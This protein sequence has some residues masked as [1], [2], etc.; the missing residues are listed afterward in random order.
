MSKYLLKTPFRELKVA[1]PVRMDD[2]SLKVF[3]GYRV[4]HS[5]ARGPAKGGIRYHPSVDIDEVRSLAEAMTWKTALAK[6][7]FGGAKGGVNCDPLE[8]SQAEV[9]CDA[10][11]H[12]P[13]SSYSRSI[14]RYSR[15]R[16]QH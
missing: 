12:F 8:M 2:G 16:R 11:V 3:S 1:V 15:A 9:E 4:Q 5:G 6:I 13:H 14:P 7:P 10:E